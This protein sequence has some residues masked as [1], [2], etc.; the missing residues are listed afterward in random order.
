MAVMLK[1]HNVPG[2]CECC[3]VER[4]EGSSGARARRSLRKV[5]RQ[6]EN[7]QWRREA[8]A[9]LRETY[10]YDEDDAAYEREIESLYD[11]VGALYS[12]ETFE[13]Y[14]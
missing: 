12:Y 4:R 3:T 8:E 14:V 6:R 2:F 1:G 10:G 9:E 11:T 7:R 5:L 13:E